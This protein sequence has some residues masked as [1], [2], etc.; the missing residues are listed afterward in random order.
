MRRRRTAYH[1]NPQGREHAH[2]HA[3]RDAV[4]HTGTIT[5]PITRHETHA[6]T[7]A[8]VSGQGFDPPLLL[9]P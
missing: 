8:P 6:E 4:M 2:P 1:A 5:R 7:G 3:G 9:F